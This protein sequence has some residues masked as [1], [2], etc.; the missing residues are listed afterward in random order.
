M[1]K[2]LCL[3]LKHASNQEKNKFYYKLRRSNRLN[4]TQYQ[5]TSTTLSVQ[6]W[7]AQQLNS[8]SLESYFYTFTMPLKSQDT[9][10][11]KEPAEPSDK[12]K[13]IHVA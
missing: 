5:Y 6:L 10:K 13:Q 1:L 11:T 9:E 8:I 3:L 4:S 12:G 7:P 2:G